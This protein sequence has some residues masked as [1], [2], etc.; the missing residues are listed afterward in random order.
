MGIGTSLSDN[1][2]T[3]VL[4]WSPSQK[5]VG[6]LERRFSRQYTFFVSTNVAFESTLK[7][8]SSILW[9]KAR[10]QSLWKRDQ[11][12]ITYTVLCCYIV[13]WRIMLSMSVFNFPLS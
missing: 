1:Y 12:S 10:R 5:S 7:A 2:Q 9:L 3:S 6:P 13:S 11:L 8:T 4:R